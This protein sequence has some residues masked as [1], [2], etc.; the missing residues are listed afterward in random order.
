MLEDT[1]LRP[2]SQLAAIIKDTTEYGFDMSSDSRTGSL[3]RFLS[4]G[5]NSGQ[6]LEIGTGTGISACW[7]LDGMTDDA[8]LTSVDNDASVQEIAKKHLES[9]LR[10]E[11]VLG[12]GLTELG[13][14][15]EYSVDLIFADSWPGKFQQVNLALSKLKLGGIYLIDDLLPQPNW[16]ERHQINVDRLV[17]NLESNP[18]L[19]TIKLDWSSGLLLARRISP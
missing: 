2:P 15:Q 5:I 19:E 7:I 10:A 8:M 17:D 1:R 9:D 12:D 11:F 13:K 16:P 14:I 18:S 4:S 6:I 3:L